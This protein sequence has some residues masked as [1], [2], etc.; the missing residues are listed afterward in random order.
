MVKVKAKRE[1]SRMTEKEREYEERIDRLMHNLGLSTRWCVDDLTITF[2]TPH[3]F[4]GAV[5]VYVGVGHDKRVYQYIEG[6]TNLDLWRA[7][8]ALYR[9]TNNPNSKFIE[10]F[11]MTGENALL[12]QFGV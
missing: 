4:K 3:R 8:D 11:K 5:K 10:G 6:K 12:V 9:K 7:A 1:A 2:D